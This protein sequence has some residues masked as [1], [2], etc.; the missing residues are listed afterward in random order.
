M[1]GIEF[2]SK[3]RTEKEKTT[4]QRKLTNTIYIRAHETYSA[5]GYGKRTNKETHSG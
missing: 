2:R 4:R 3:K 1:T 5:K